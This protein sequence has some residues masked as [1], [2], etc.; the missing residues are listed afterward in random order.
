MSIPSKT[1]QVAA[2]ALVMIA[3]GGCDKVIFPVEH[4]VAPNAFR[5]NAKRW[6][7]SV[8]EVKVWCISGEKEIVWYVKATRK[9]P[10]RGFVVT[11]GSVPDG[12]E[13]IIPAPFEAFVPTPGQQ[14]Q[15]G[16][17]G[18]FDPYAYHLETT[19]IAK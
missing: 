16:V 5:L 10:V 17:D 3:A 7:G 6:G 8:T 4:G 13:Q 12:F 15:I 2:I 9:I 14:Y 11:V 1:I 18:D 19:W